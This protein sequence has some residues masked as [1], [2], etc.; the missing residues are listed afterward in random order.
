MSTGKK[1][2]PTSG[3]S[4]SRAIL[5]ASNDAIFIYDLR[6]GVLIDVNRRAEELY[7]YSREAMLGRS[8]SMIGSEMPSH[9]EE[10]ALQWILNGCDGKSQT[11]D[12]MAKHANS[13][14][15]PVE[16]SVSTEEVDGR[17]LVIA[18]VRDISDRKATENSLRTSRQQLASHIENTPLAAIEYDLDWN[19]TQWNSA[20]ETIFGFSRNETIGKSVQLII[21]EN[22]RPQ[23]NLTMKALYEGTGGIRS[24]NTN[25]TKDGRIILCDWH[26]T[27]L[28][29]PAGE[30]CGVASLVIDITEGHQSTQALQNFFEQSGSL[31]IIMNLAGTI[32]RINQGA[33]EILDYA[34]EELAD[35]SI[36]DLFH[37]EDAAGSAR[38]IDR[39]KEGKI[40]SKFENRLRHKN[41]EY[42]TLSWSATS[43]LQDQLI[44]AIGNDISD[45]KK[46]EKLAQGTLDALSAHIAILDHNGIIISVNQRWKEFAMENG[47][48]PD[49]DLTE[50]NYLAVC[51]AAIGE[52][53]KDAEHFAQGLRSVLNG[54]TNFFE[55]EYPCQTERKLY[56]FT[57][58]ITA[59]DEAPPRRIAVAHED[60]T[61]RKLAEIAMQ[62]SQEKYK[63]LYENAPLSYQSLDENG[64]L[65]D[66]NP[67][68]LRMLGYKR[69]HVIGSSFGD[70][71][72]PDQRA[73]FDKNF[74]E[75]KT[76]GCV[77]DVH[78]KIRHNDGNYRIISLEGSI[79]HHADGGFKQTYCVFQDI[80][81]Q[82]QAI[83]ALK[84]SEENL[85]SLVDTLPLAIYLSTGVEE[86]CEYINPTF[87]ELF[88]YTIDDVPSMADWGPKAYPDPSS[89]TRIEE[90]WGSR[91]SRAIETNRS[92]EPME[93]VVTCKDG[94][95]KTML[96]GFTNIGEKNYSYGLDLTDIRNTEQALRD[97]NRKFETLLTNLPGMVYRCENDTNWTM[98][99]LSDGCRELTGYTASDLL[100]CTGV[101]YGDLIHPDDRQRIWDTIQQR[102]AGKAPYEVEFRLITKDGSQKWV[103]ERGCG[104]YSDTGKLLYLEGFITDITAHKEARAALRKSEEQYRLLFENMTTSFAVH[105]MIYDA[106][107]QPVD[108][109]FLQVNPAFEEMT[110]VKSHDLLGRTASEVFPDTEVYWIEHFGHVARTGQPLLFE[111]Y[112]DEF[113]KY[114]EANAFCPDPGLVAVI[115][116]DITE[117]RQADKI[118]KESEER[119]RGMLE[120]LPYL[121][122]LGFG[123][124]G[125]IRFWNEGSERI[126][127][128]TKE[129]ALGARMMDLIIPE[130]LRSSVERAIIETEKTGTLPPASECEFLRKGGSL[131]PVLTS[132]ASNQKKGDDFEMFCLDVEISGLKNAKQQLQKLSDIQGLILNNS[133]LGIAL[134]KNRKFEW[135]N[136]R[137]SELFLIPAE[138]LAGASSRLLYLSEED[139]IKLGEVIYNELVTQQR[140]DRDVQFKRRDGSAFW[141]RLIGKALDP[142]RPDEGSIWMFEDITEKKTTEIELLRLSTA[143]EQSPESVVITDLR[144]YIQYANPTFEQ[145]SGYSRQEVIGQNV[146]LLRSGEHTRAFYA[147]LWKTIESG[148]IWKGRLVNKRKDESH[149][150]EDVII[151][152]VKDSSGRITNYVAIKRD[153]T[154]ELIREEEFRQAQKMEAV[155]Q[156]AGGI[157]HDFN[158]ILQGIQGF[159]EM[160][161]TS[162]PSESVEY[163]NA[164]EIQKAA[165]RAAELTRQLLTFSRKQPVLFTPLDLNA[166]IHDSQS[167]LDVLLGDITSIEL[168]LQQELP[169]INADHGQWSQIIMNLAV[170]ARD[171]MPGGGRV[172]LT[173]R[174]VELNEEDAARTHDAEAGVY[175]CLSVTDTGQGMPNHV[176]DRL[177]EPFFTT[178]DIGNG[179][180]LGLAV[181][182]GIVKQCNGWINVYSEPGKGSCFSLYV[183]AI[184]FKQP[185][186]VHNA[187]EPAGNLRILLIEDDPDV[188]HLVMEILKAEHYT[189]IAA[190]SAEE[191]LTRF[192]Q[193][194]GRFDLLISDMVLPGMRGDE[195][196]DALRTICPTLPVLLYSGYHDQKKRWPDLEKK[197]YYFTN[198]PFHKKNFTGIIRE[199]LKKT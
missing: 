192:K 123:V 29:D 1:T 189:P 105:E 109:R 184:N 59:F 45:S 65:Q 116:S 98:K 138:L 111:E 117:R 39:L 47:A 21:P 173:T 195:L 108:Y 193:E 170:N 187:N 119:F 66:V 103:W 78:Y 161:K 5:D 41:G 169:L 197:N 31:H 54:E 8:I 77:S 183:P 16:I 101:V 68:W 126:Y 53:A 34:P 141:C 145:T 93:T 49:T 122:V 86:T 164:F 157:A 3:V 97:S 178:K 28:T 4:Y 7:G 94:T 2:E 61:A 156:L 130:E 9:T 180:G 22:I 194:Q 104:Y 129:E 151:S 142:I 58:R 62:E 76:S 19:I 26:N 131:I 120:K 92:I 55:M 83:E 148:R 99:F 171:A 44:Y 176:I 154:E 42:R 23:M 43:S 85:R 137:L 38:Q 13:S 174:R 95:T 188:E 199:V 82:H 80:T 134:V 133:T 36:Y 84:E 64:C 127:G 96:W 15:F 155:G 52:G 172:T 90:Q 146:H 198:K 88:G 73:H 60:V 69:E 56:W 144:G 74:Q 163:D 143:I 149:F 27:V 110:G 51:D 181:V 37:P 75:L 191:G 121:A 106:E 14:L 128:Y 153:I 102:L 30:I 190:A 89:R 48:P 158:N 112:S 165:K 57:A 20:A 136:P 11:I 63:A 135:V 12:G 185:E 71:L 124:D 17:T 132:H 177:F 50:M 18:V 6:P 35:S 24:R 118:M 182:Y 162:L 10:E 125:R 140:V 159:S 70:F 72:H 33:K 168:D 107:G 160:L 46:A 114:Y 115:V 87:S 175:C 186:P 179:T 32:L 196:A 100:N 147:E 81:E 152:P 166:V 113:D 25:I 40:V 91:I 67:A 167:L 139:F 150:T 79:G